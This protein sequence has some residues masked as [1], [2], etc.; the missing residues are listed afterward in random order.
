SMPDGPVKSR[1][2]MGWWEA[3]VG[4]VVGGVLV[5]LMPNFVVVALSLLF[6]LV[7]LYFTFRYV[8]EVGN[9]A[10]RFKAMATFGFGYLWMIPGGGPILPAIQKVRG[11]AEPMLGANSL[12]QIGGA[13]QEHASD[14]N[15]QYP[16][17][18]ITDSN[19][20]PLLSWRVAILPYLGE[21]NLYQQ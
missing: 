15:D 19:G 14:H 10:E 1:E 5:A 20:K 17:A 3:I 7:W 8:V 18:A 21:H 9:C 12:K 6:L 11:A 16:P 2:G 4:T 13:F